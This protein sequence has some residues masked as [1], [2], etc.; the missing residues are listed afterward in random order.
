MKPSF[1]AAHFETGGK[2][3]F[4]TFSKLVDKTDT[5]HFKVYFEEERVS[6]VSN[7]SNSSSW[8]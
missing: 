2:H 1:F 8:I 4:D 7:L 5:W 3:F 6:M